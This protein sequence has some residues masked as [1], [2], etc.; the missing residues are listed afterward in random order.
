MLFVIQFIFSD[1]RHT[2]KIGFIL[3]NT[4]VVAAAAAD[5]KKKIRIVELI[6]FSFVDSKRF[7]SVLHK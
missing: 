4:R 7:G 6:Q 2:I 5:L 1:T 3:A